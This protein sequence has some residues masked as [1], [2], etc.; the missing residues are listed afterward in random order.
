M[1]VLYDHQIFS[2]QKFGGILRYFCGILFHFNN[3]K[4][5]S[6]EVTLLLSDN[7]YLYK[8]KIIKYINFLPNIQFR[9]KHRLSNLINKPYSII[10]L[11]KQ[12]YDI[13]HPTYYDP[14]FLEYIGN[15]PFVLTVHDMIHEKFSW[16]FP[17]NDKT[18]EHKRLLV[19]KASKII[20]V[21]ECTKKDLVELFGTDESKIEVV[22][23]GNS[24]FPKSN[25]KISYD[26]P[27]KYLLFVGNRD[28]YKNFERFIKSIS[29]ILKQDKKSW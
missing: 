26:I 4:D 1:K 14:Y 9:G 16:M 24:L 6:T 22:Y 28:L 29:D 20:A 3:I 11:K 19:E 25:I 13:F 10:A 23:H 8:T 15:K 18:T 2:M 17:P 5:I 27:N 7:H 21:S 12:N